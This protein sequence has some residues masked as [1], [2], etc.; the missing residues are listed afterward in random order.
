MRPPRATR[1]NSSKAGYRTTKDGRRAW[2]AI[3]KEVKP[4][5]SNNIVAAMQKVVNFAIDHSVKP[6]QQLNELETLMRQ[7]DEVK[8]TP[9]TQE[10]RFDYIVVALNRAPG[11]I[12]GMLVYDIDD[13]RAEG[14]LGSIET[15]KKKNVALCV[16]HLGRQAGD[17]FILDV[18]G[19][20]AR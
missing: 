2:I 3:Y 15:V 9:L 4:R 7:Y 19:D 1:K 14:E 13:K 10:E 11:D 17:V 6:E 5:I 12:Y 18:E 20:S 16:H 8:G